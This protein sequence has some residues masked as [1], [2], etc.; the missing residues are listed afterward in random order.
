MEKLRSYGNDKGYVIEARERNAGSKNY[1]RLL[2]SQGRPI[3]DCILS[4]SAGWEVDFFFTNEENKNKMMNKVS[5]DL[6]DKVNK[7][8]DYQ[9]KVFYVT[10]V[11]SLEVFEELMEIYYDMH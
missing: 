11:K 8:T 7:I 4:K 1:L 6:S 10:G 5:D 9:K 3:I 2:D